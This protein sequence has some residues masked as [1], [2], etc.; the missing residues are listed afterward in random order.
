MWR[1]VLHKTLNPFVDIFCSR[2]ER[3]VLRVFRAKHPQFLDAYSQ[4]VEVREDRFVVGVFF[5][6][7]D[8]PRYKFFAVSRD[9]V[10][11]RELEDD[12]AYRARG[13]R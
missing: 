2:A 12:S 13:W 6:R 1:Q 3:V 10:E 4:L 7:C 5:G 9:L 8:P 11:V